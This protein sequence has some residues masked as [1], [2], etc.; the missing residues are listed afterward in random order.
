MAIYMNSRYT[1]TPVY[2]REGALVFKIRNRPVF[3]FKDSFMHTVIEGDSLDGLAYR[4]YG[5]SHLWWVILE[6]NEQYNSPYDI[7]NGDDLL[8]PSYEEVREL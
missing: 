1:R 7:C 8:L 4:Y 6:A 3:T 5:D 2:N